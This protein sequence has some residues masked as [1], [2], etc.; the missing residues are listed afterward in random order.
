M[1][2]QAEQNESLLV[3]A[4]QK[5]EKEAFRLLLTQNWNWIRALVYSIV[6]DTDS[7]DDVMQDIC[8]QVIRK[9]D[10]LREPGRFRPWMAVLARRQALKYRQRKNQ[11]RIVSLNNEEVAGQ[12]CDYK[13]GQL[14]DNLELRERY[15]QILQ[16]VKSL[17]EMYRQVFV[18]AHLENLS[19]AQIAEI[20]DVPVTTVQIRL[21]R[22]RR[23]IF[24]QVKDKEKNEV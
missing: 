21:V 13:A 7:V 4:A 2:W 1:A 12:Q 8:V 10:T 17:P 19:Y 16:A 15:Q 22:A 20:L 3:F 9:V 24:N 5:G 18:L 14:L 23:M 6:N 11:R